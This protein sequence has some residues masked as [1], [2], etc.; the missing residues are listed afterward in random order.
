MNTKRL[1]L[2]LGA[3]VVVAAVVVVGGNLVTQIKEQNAQ[4]KSL[5]SDVVDLEMEVAALEAD[6]SDLTEVLFGARAARD[7]CADQSEAYRMAGLKSAESMQTW[8]KDIF[9]PK[10]DLSEATGYIDAANLITCEQ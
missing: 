1:I 9:G 3:V 4:L 8:L 5:V 7:L 6:N 10:L 2:T